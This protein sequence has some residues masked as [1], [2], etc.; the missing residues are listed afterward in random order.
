MR[1]ATA[2][3]PS[4]VPLWRRLP[5]GWR[6][7]VLILGVLL[8]SACSLVPRAFDSS[9]RTIRLREAP[10][11]VLCGR[12][13]ST[14]PC[15]LILQEDWEDLVIDYKAKCLLLGGSP[16]RCQTILTPK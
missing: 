16:E 14:V 2:Y 13:A 8:L 4:S 11:E 7:H 12:G 15:L 1:H 10:A 3:L 6:L 5:C 9:T